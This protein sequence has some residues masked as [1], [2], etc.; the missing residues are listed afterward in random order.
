[1]L[2]SETY[3][4]TAVKFNVLYNCIKNDYCLLKNSVSI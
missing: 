1:M 2:A 4:L 3:N